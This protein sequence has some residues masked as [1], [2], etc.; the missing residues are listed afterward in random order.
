MAELRNRINQAQDRPRMILNTEVNPKNAR[1]QIT[2]AELDIAGY[3]LHTTELSSKHSIRGT[4][5]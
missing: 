4:C 2:E 3:E 1:Y 5:I